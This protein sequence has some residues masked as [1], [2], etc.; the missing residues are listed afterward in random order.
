MGSRQTRLGAVALVTLAVVAM[1]AGLLQSANATP[2][3]TT[4]RYGGDNRYA[5]A[6][7]LAEQ[8]FPN[9]ATSVV[10][11]RGED[12][13]DGT[14]G[15][16]D[17]LAGNYLAGYVGGPILLTDAD[18]V[19]PETLDALQTLKV[20]Q[21][22]ILGGTYAVSDAVSS[23]LETTASTNSAGGDLVVGRIAGADRYQTAAMTAEQ[24]PASKVGLFD[25]K[26]TALI[27][28]GDNFPDALAAGP[29]AAADSFPLLLT[30]TDSLN[31]YTAEAL[32]ALNIQQAIIVGGT[33]SV[34]PT[35]EASIQQSGVSTIRIG[36]S[37]RQQTAADLATFAIEYLGFKGTTVDLA[38][39]DTYPDALAA[40]PEA[41]KAGPAPIVLTSSPT[42]LSDET[43]DWIRQWDSSIDQVDAL[44]LE[45]AISDSVLTQATDDAVCTIPAT[46]TTTSPG[47]LGTLGLGGLLGGAAPTTTSTSTTIGPGASACSPL[48]TSTTAAGSSGSTGSTTTT[49][50][51]ETTTT[52]PGETTTT[53][54]GATTTTTS[55]SLLGL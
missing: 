49:T 20:K 46:T 14:E 45:G 44:G 7:A 40:G 21:V 29:L 37:D 35:V 16:A 31:Q 51:G 48:P 43:Q 38:R 54:A 25:S 19:P 9:G 22:G 39:G 36:G 10:L 53:A 1:W 28:T 33:S 23:E 30:N 52:T 41:A 18:D 55:G 2:E 12:F 47:L 34:S 8:A 27:T 42:V 4:M 17:A 5:T 13:P 3:V 50:P 26:R 32:Q 6:A 24:V 11:A 15:F